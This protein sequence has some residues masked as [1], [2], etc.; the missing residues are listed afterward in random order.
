MNMS[1]WILFSMTAL[2]ASFSEGLWGQTCP[3]CPTICTNRCSPSEC[4]GS[5]GQDWCRFPGTGCDVDWLNV[6]SGCCELPLTP[7]VIDIRGNGF[8]LT[9]AEHGV[10]FDF[11]GNG[12]KVQVAWTERD[13]DDAW[14]VLDR[15]GN[16]RIDS[17]KEMFGNATVQPG[18]ASPNGFLALAVFDEPA[19][20]GNGDGV[21]DAKD[22]IFTSLRLWQDK[23]HDGISQPDELFTLPALGVESISLDFEE[24]RRVDEFG[25]RF[26]Y[27][28][29]VDDAKHAHVGRFA[30]DVF[31]KLAAK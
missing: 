2:L 20:G 15:D 28:A 27:R 25:N 26:R 19:N 18:N 23:N 22:A 31:L 9:D 17:G 5:A 4:S 16:G 21:I 13:S 11:F 12:H 29:V 3:S 14:L 10:L 8:A 30:Y 24:S 1:R 7:I 6:G